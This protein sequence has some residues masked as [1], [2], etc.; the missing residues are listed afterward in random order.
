MPLQNRKKVETPGGVQKKQ[1]YLTFYITEHII[2][3]RFM[4]RS[5]GGDGIIK[6]QIGD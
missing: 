2:A 6:M 5:A 4:R 1:V 3:G